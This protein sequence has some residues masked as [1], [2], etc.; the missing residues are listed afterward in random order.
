[1]SAVLLGLMGSEL[2]R[3]CPR[4]LVLI[5]GILIVVNP[6]ELSARYVQGFICDADKRKFSRRQDTGMRIIPQG[7]VRSSSMNERRLVW[8]PW[9]ILGPSP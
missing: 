6:S 8:S 2:N 9:D 5:K 4:R 3:R 7:F 1:M